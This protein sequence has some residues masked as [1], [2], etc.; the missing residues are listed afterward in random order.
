MPVLLGL[1]LGLLLLEAAPAG[2]VFRPGTRPA[3]PTT[4]VNTEMVM[5][6]VG[7]GTAVNGFIN[8]DP[9]FDPVHTAYPNALTPPAGFST[10]D[11][12]FAGI[13]HGTP[14]PNPNN[15][16]LRLYCI[17]I[18]TETTNGVGYVLGTWDQTGVP[19]VG[20]VARLLNEY[21]P[22]GPI[23]APLSEAQTA[24]AVQ[25][26]IWYF[27][28]HF[29]LRN[30]DPV[31]NTDRFYNTVAGIVFHIQHSPPLVTPPPPT[32]NIDPSTGLAGPHRVLGPFTVTTDHPP[33]TVTA[34]A[35][36]RM[37]SDSPGG[38]T[39]ADGSTVP[40]GQK[41]WLH[42]TGPS[43]A[44]LHAT[45]T[46]TV[47]SGNVYVYSHNTGRPDAQRL[48]LAQPATLTTTVQVTAT[49]QPFGKLVVKK[50][51]G[52]PAAG[53]QGKVVIHVDC[54]DGVTR[55]DFVIPAGA[56]TG[57]TSRIYRH[58]VAGTKCLVT[59][60]ANG[61]TR[62]TT[63]VVTGNGQEPTISEGETQTVE[64]K[65]TY[66]FAPS[67]LVVRKTIAGPAAGKQGEVTIHTVCNG[68]A[69]TPDFEI[70]A[71]TPASARTMKYRLIRTPARCRITETVDG[72]TSTVSVVVEG[73][74]QT[75]RVPPGRRVTA[76]ISDTYGLR[77]GELEVNK[78]IDG[79]A[80]GKQ[81]EV[82]IHTVCN[83]TALTPDFVIPAGTPAG[84][85]SHIYSGLP[86]KASCTVTET[87]D[88]HTGAVSVV[89]AGSPH[90]TTIP[91]GGGAA[92]TIT[93]T[94]GALPG[95]LLVTK[96]IAGPRAGHQGPV[97]IH[98]VCDGTALSPDFVIAARTPAGTV[99]H[100]FDN[101][102]AG[103]VCTVTE[104]ASG[105]SDTV[106]VTASGDG[107]TVTIPAA[108]VVPVS[109]MDVYREGSPAAEGLGSLTVIKHITGP[110][111]RRHGRIAI[112]V[113]C[114]GPVFD[115]A[116]VIPAHT[117][118]GLVT[119]HFDNI[120][121]GSRCA[122]TEVAVGR[123]NRVTVVATGR[124][125]HATIPATGTAIVR[126][127]DKFTRAVTITRPPRPR[128]TG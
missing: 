27:T 83:G 45:S 113:A 99:S 84:V 102:P 50:T 66:R 88:G 85:K 128:V 108:T 78:T 22:N 125:Q 12:G 67:L 51:I 1:A 96:T 4:R 106:I 104:T 52:G 30:P 94:Y 48:I 87:V 73:S 42:Q 120:P 56:P 107:Q 41:I 74:G 23:L 105:A 24:A 9:L 126:L 17:D 111:A 82:V 47:P 114:G 118:P 34:N 123:T 75:V 3:R 121:A 69:L 19:N 39:I 91:A 29:V 49:F 2:A 64:I 21:Y 8:T 14:V 61:S 25:A 53:H 10:H 65:D 32:L 5:S 33:A 101:I 100:S 98:V 97:T 70:H 13:I 71:G 6:G 124:R 55:P 7:P 31:N 46:A 54:D 20:F 63:V 72:H 92:A 40:S 37:S 90:T 26:A 79:P 11:A 62:A 35:T 117:G 112:L 89:V 127:S 44:V 38:P 16:T 15:E 57:T 103:A 115:F 76:N 43:T 109:L 58:I 18:L 28:D 80:A 81:G 110:A 116:F 93:D 95:S 36:A 77:S 68:K 59:E 119:R 86:A 122:V 60:T